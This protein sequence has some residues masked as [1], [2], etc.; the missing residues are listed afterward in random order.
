MRRFALW[1]STGLGIGYI[2]FASGTFGTLW[3]ALLF[4]L[5]RDLP[6]QLTAG[7]ILLFIL[8]SVYCAQRA[9]EALGGHDSSRI[10]IDEVAG[11]LVA[12]I[13]IPFSWRTMLLAFLLFRLFDIAKPYPIRQIDRRWGGGWG[14][15]MDDVLAGVFSNLSLRLIMWVWGIL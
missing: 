2:P 8:F 12:V 10:V 9:E 7:A 5:S 15:V 13:A 6:W 3:G 11:Y 1:M 4:Y 14:V